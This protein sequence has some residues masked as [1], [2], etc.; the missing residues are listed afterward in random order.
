MKIVQQNIKL[1]ITEINGGGGCTAQLLQRHASNLMPQQPIRALFAGASGCGKTNALLNL[2]YSPYGLSFKNIY[3][4][5]KSR[6]QPKYQEME[7]ILS[8]V[9]EIG[10]FA[11][12]D[13]EEVVAPQNAREHSIFIF[14]DIAIEPQS[15]V[16]AYYCMGRHKNIDSF[17]LT[18][19]YVCCQK[20]LVRD[21]LNFICL[22]KM[23][24]IN[25][26]HAYNEHVNTDMSFQDFFQMCK[27][28]WGLGKFACLVIDKT[29]D[30]NDGRYRCNFDSFIVFNED[31]KN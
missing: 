22:F 16:R 3:L 12:D 8:L 14:D 4:Y 31:N 20:H 29:R 24:N 1:P 28:V 26:K 9:P 23:D 30:L 25:L 5:S 7:K 11:F 10:Y 17:Y 13:N 21:N 6:F 15:N 27:T 19:T 18:Q 2:I